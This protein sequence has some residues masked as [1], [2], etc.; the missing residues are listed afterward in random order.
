MFVLV[1]WCVLD[2][3]IVLYIKDDDAVGRGRLQECVHA[4]IEDVRSHVAKP[5]RLDALLH[6]SYDAL[7]GT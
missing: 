5:T 6:S 1:Y 2:A 7:I 4:V 3:K